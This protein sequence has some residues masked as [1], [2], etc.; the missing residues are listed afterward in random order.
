MAIIEGVQYFAKIRAVEKSV[1]AYV[2]CDS[3][4]TSAKFD[5]FEQTLN[6]E[7]FEIRRIL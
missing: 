2:E 7:G 6:L 3:E 1:E 5:E 4:S